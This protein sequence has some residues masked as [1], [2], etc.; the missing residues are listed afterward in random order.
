MSLHSA[1][2]VNADPTRLNDHLRQCVCAL[3]PM[4]RAR[5]AVESLDAF[6]APRFVSLLLVMTVLVLVV[7]FV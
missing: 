4:H 3:G 1:L 2:S 5:C 6:L 7:A